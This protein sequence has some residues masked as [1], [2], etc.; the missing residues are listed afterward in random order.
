MKLDY[1]KHGIDKCNQRAMGVLAYLEGYLEETSKPEGYR[2]KAEKAF[3][4]ELLKIIN[5]RLS[6]VAIQEGETQ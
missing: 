5:E 2:S 1:E 3:A 4:Q 6:D